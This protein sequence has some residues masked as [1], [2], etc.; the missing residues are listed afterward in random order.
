MN[1][2]TSFEWFAVICGLVGMYIVLSDDLRDK[3]REYKDLTGGS[4]GK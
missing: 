3:W 2:L 4:N 1:E